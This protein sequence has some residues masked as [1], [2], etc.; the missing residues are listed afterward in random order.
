M[1]SKLLAQLGLQNLKPLMTALVLPPVPLMLLM[2]LAAR[3]LARRRWGGWLLLWLS[4]VG[5]WLN[6]C[7][8]WGRL[9]ETHWLSMPPVLTSSRLDALR[10]TTDLP[11]AIVILGGGK[12]SLA[13]EYAAS[14]LSETSL[15]RLRYGIWLSRATGLPLAFSGGVGWGQVASDSEAEVAARIAKEEFGKDLKW[16]EGASRDTRENAARTVPLLQAD[17]IRH[18]LVVTNA[19]HMPRALRAFQQAAQG[20]PMVI[21]AAPMGLGSTVESANLEWV[22]TAEGF[23]RVRRVAREL[24]GTALGF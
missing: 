6:G 10:S 3:R 21:E 18:V 19:W 23:L 16:I 8:G 1:L 20:T 17:G 4:L 24:L 12:E 7:V 2:L 9:L 11:S 14:N 5:L 15:E 13:P 22:P